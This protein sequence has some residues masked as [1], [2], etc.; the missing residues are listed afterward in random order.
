VK[1]A[2]NL[3]GKLGESLASLQKYDALPQNVTTPL[4][5]ILTIRC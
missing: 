2:S 1:A 4:L 3:R 5:P